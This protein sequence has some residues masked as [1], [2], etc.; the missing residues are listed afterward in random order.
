MVSDKHLLKLTI[1]GKILNGAH[2]R[3]SSSSPRERERERER[4]RN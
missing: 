4:E 2:T 3:T 1:P